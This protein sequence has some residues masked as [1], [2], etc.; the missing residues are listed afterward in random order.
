MILAP[1]APIQR[2]CSLAAVDIHQ[3]PHP[4]N[5]VS[6]IAKVVFKTIFHYTLKVEERR[7]KKG[8]LQAKKRARR[9]LPKEGERG[10]LKMVPAMSTMSSQLCYCYRGHRSACAKVTPAPLEF[11]RDGRTQ[12]FRIQGAVCCWLRARSVVNAIGTL[13]PVA[14]L[15]FSTSLFAVSVC[16]G[17]AGAEPEPSPGASISAWL[18][19]EAGSPATPSSS[20]ADG[21]DLRFLANGSELFFF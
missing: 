1:Y 18:L 19:A 6:L 14:S 2:Q 17:R 7:V 12:R 8:G 10:E 5:T 9:C 20:P 15:K 4:I 11:R 3:N 16:S 21:E 13:P